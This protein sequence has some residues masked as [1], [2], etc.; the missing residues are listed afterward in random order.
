MQID[1][2][3]LNRVQTVELLKRIGL[4][5]SG[6]G[7]EKR[8]PAEFR[9]RAL[10]NCGDRARCSA[11]RPRDRAPDKRRPPSCQIARLE[12]RQ[13]NVDCGAG[14]YSTQPKL[15]CCAPAT[16]TPNTNT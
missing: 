6:G 11:P 5:R 3:G 1:G 4:L 7:H 12:P 15:K 9:G 10:H 14:R 2:C 8:G 16:Y 13:T